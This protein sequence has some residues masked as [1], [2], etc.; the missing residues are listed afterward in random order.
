MKIKPRLE[1]LRQLIER[2]EDEEAEVEIETRNLESENRELIERILKEEESAINKLSEAE[3]EALKLL[4]YET[5][6]VIDTVEEIIEWER[7]LHKICENLNKSDLENSLSSVSRSA[8]EL[9]EMRQEY[10]KINNQEIEE[11]IEIIVNMPA[12]IGVLNEMGNSLERI[13]EDERKLDELKDILHSEEMRKRVLDQEKGFLFIKER[14]QEIKSRREKL[15]QIEE[16]QEFLEEEGGVNISESI[17]AVEEFKESRKEDI[18]ERQEESLEQLIEELEEIQNLEQ[19]Y[20][21][22]EKSRRDIIKAL[23]AIL[24]T[25]SEINRRSDGAILRAAAR[26]LSG[27]YPSLGNGEQDEPRGEHEASI[28][29][30]ATFERIDEHKFLCENQ[31]C[32]AVV[33]LEE[34]YED[35]FELDANFENLIDSRVKAGI[36]WDSDIEFLG[37]DSI[38][39]DREITI[40]LGEEGDHKINGRFR[41]NSGSRLQIKFRD[42]GYIERFVFNLESR[43]GNLVLRRELATSS[44]SI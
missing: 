9:S 40:F 11:A 13:G 3:K 29:S 7:N 28:N 36:E 18:S 43:N 32:R 20:N 31:L 35:S 21:E 5:G 38:T 8:N 19:S 17:E 33:S 15:K 37:H 30:D 4:T 22:D 14:F 2:S 1:K 44:G 39:E 12:T 16:Y 42:E 26:L 41:A 23:M 34:E 25:S 27:G 10:T 6:E 24:G